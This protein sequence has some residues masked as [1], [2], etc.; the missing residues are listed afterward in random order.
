MA[1]LIRQSSSLLWSFSLSSS[2]PIA[3]LLKKSLLDTQVSLET[4]KE[5][6]GSHIISNSALG[7]SLLVSVCVCSSSSPPLFISGI[8]SYFEGEEDVDCFSSSLSD[9]N[10]YPSSSFSSSAS[11]KSSFASSSSNSVLTSSFVSND[12]LT[13][14][15]S[16]SVSS[17]CSLSMPRDNNLNSS[18][19][20]SSNSSSTSSSMPKDDI[21]K[22]SD[23]HLISESKDN[24]LKGS[25]LHATLKGTDL[26][27]INRSAFLGGVA[28]S[29]SAIV[30][31]ISSSFTLCPLCTF[32]LQIPAI[33]SS[34]IFPSG[35]S[36]SSAFLSSPSCRTINHLANIAP[37]VVVSLFSF[38]LGVV[39]GVPPHGTKQLNSAPKLLKA[40][41]IL[42]VISFLKPNKWPHFWCGLPGIESCL[43][44]DLGSS[45]L[46]ICCSF[47]SPP[48]LISLV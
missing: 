36:N 37:Q 17:N 26:H 35:S 30:I 21:P 8:S 33:T 16:F 18:F 43:S 40:S 48:K 5:S 15:S 11:S 25:D 39:E 23:P 42:K 4:S 7:N 12:I 24:L 44:G 1:A 22:A 46:D 3:G 19:S 28:I 10:L 14:S 41:Q 2:V 20:T 47:L 29:S 13:S 6:F 34:T 45:P 38:V 27:L 32:S 9:W 31:F